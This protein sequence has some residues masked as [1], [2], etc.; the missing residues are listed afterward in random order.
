MLLALRV[1]LMHRKIVL[2][3]Q[4]ARMHAHVVDWDASR[5][6]SGG[7]LAVTALPH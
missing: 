6:A 1:H 3:V 2:R 4:K 5:L 7:E